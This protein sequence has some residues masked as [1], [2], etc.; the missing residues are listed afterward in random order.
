MPLLSEENKL[1]AEIGPIKYIAELFYSKEDP[2][3]IDKAVRSVIL[4][5]IAVFDPLAILLLIA[6]NQ[7]YRKLKEPTEEPLKKAK[8]KKTL[9]NSPTNSLES[10]FIDDTNEIIPKTQITKMEKGSF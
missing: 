6:S 4:I 7:T 3:F 5:I 2:N 10:F 9:D 8:K 1:T